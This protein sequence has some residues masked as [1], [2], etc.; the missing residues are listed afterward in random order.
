[1]DWNALSALSSLFAAIGVNVTVIYLAVQVRQNTL[2][3]RAVSF[4]AITDSFNAINLDI[5]HDKELARLWLRGSVDLEQ[6]DDAEAFQFGMLVLSLLRVHESVYY[7]SK[8]GTMDAEMREA[9]HRSLQFVFA[10]PGTRAW[11]RRNTI[12]FAREFREHIDRLID[13]LERAE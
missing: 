6:L 12:S 5:A 13:T 10:Q 4:N 2:E 11:W 8:R 9:E 3:T 7:Q 1:M